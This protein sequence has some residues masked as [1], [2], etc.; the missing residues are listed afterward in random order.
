ME[1]LKY[2][3]GDFLEKGINLRIQELK[4]QIAIATNEAKLPPSVLQMIFNEF[5]VQMQ[6]QNVEA[7]KAEKESYMKE[8]AKDGKEIHKD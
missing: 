3:D 4:E 1:L 7:I 8:G 5:A 2:K 6:V